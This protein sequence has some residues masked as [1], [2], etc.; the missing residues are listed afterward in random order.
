MNR[1]ELIRLVGGAAAWPFAASAQQ[2]RKQHRLAFVHSGIPAKE[3]TKTAGPFWV[4]RF[5]ETLEKLGHAEGGNL[6]VERYSA[7]GRSDRFA[8]LAAG[9]RTYQRPD[10]GRPDCQSGTAGR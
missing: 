9:R 2:P 1:R 7:E 8:A 4:R 10:P 6:V 5:F 3:L